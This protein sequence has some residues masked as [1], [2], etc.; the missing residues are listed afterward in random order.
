MPTCR[1]H[2]AHNAHDSLE[3]CVPRNTPQGLYGKISDFSAL[4]LYIGVDFGAAARFTQNNKN[5]IAPCDL[6]LSHPATPAYR[7]A[8]PQTALPK[9]QNSRNVPFRSTAFTPK[10]CPPITHSCH[11]AYHARI[12]GDRANMPAYSRLRA[13]AEF[14]ELPR[15][16]NDFCWNYLWH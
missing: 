11:I 9:A 1:R 7:T 6:R 10:P 13:S 8:Q 14:R 5:K 16:G 2:N 12:I 15:Y 3:E 4:C